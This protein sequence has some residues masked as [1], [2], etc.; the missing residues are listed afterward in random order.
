MKRIGLMVLAAVC[1]SVPAWSVEENLS[2]TAAGSAVNG[3]KAFTDLNCVSCHRV[4]G[5]SELPQPLPDS[6]APVLGGLSKIYTTEELSQAIASPSH[7]IAPGFHANADGSSPMLDLS[8]QM[9]VRQL[10]DVVAYLKEAE[11]NDASW[12][13]GVQKQ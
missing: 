10:L 3:R 6:A 11:D 13:N 4:F 5:D 2:F 9:T 7:S 8:S 12:T 1:L